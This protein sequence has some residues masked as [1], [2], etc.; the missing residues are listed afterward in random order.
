[1]GGFG[2]SILV[3][4]IHRIS[5]MAQKK[6][7][8]ICPYPENVAPSQRLKFEQYYPHFK[9]AGYKVDV[10]PFI[11]K[12]FFSVIY[13]KGFFLKKVFYTVAGY[14]RRIGN[15]FQ[16]HKYDIVYLH[17]WATPFGPPFFE[18]LIRKLSRRIVYDIDDLVYLKNVESKAHPLVTFIKGRK[19]PIYLMKA[20]DYVITCTPYLDEFVRK[21]NDHTI[22]ISSTVDTDERYQVVNKY[23]DGIATLG[24]SGSLSTSKYFYLLTDV[25]KELAKKYQFKI[26]VLGDD[27]VK[28]EGLDIEALSWKEETEIKDLQR[29][30]IGLYP[31]PDEEWV[32][33][34]SGLKAIQYMALGIPTVATAIGANFRVIENGVSGFLVRTKGEWIAALSQLIED[35]ALRK[36]VGQ[37]ARKRVEE[38]FSIRNNKL[39]YLQ[40]LETVLKQ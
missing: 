13:K 3:E 18:F 36:L 4:K 40:V 20:A 16:L 11:S 15:L 31:L 28:I 2:F 32:L 10:S 8:V 19:K 37:A 9:A 35:A 1:M 5:F 23:Q 7:L 29:I 30:D 24:W 25:L 6:I 39:N 34:K 22:D 33:G 38:K 12:G 14:F 27:S 21:Y 17:L 26:F